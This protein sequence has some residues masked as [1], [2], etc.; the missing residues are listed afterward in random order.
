MINNQN[1]IS[2]PNCNSVFPIDESKY[3]I[4]SQQVRTKEFNKELENKLK[5]ELSKSLKISE[6]Q[7]R[8]DF[9]ESLNNKDKRILELEAKINLQSAQDKIKFKNE[10]DIKDKE[11]NKLENKLEQYDSLSQL[12][13]KEA[14]DEKDKVI[15]NLENKIELQNANHSIEIKKETEEKEE[16]INQLKIEKSKLLAEQEISELKIKEKHLIEVTLLKDEIERRKNFQSSF[17]K[18]IGEDL[19]DYCVNQFE[20][21]RQDGFRRSTFEKDNVLINGIKGDFIFRDFDEEGD[22]IISIMF[23]MKNESDKT[24]DE[25]KKKNKEFYPTL[26]KNRIQKNCEYAVLVS[27]L[28][29]DNEFFNRGIVEINGYE[30]LFV[31]RPQFFILIIS[32]LRNMSIKKSED[33]RELQI[34]KQNNINYAVLSDN[35]N[36]FR[37]GC[38]EKI[39]LASGDFSKM[40]T[41]IDQTISKLRKLREFLL[42]AIGNLKLADNKLHKFDIENMTESMKLLT[43]G[44]DNS[45][46]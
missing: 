29:K 15:N 16:E 9:K 24:K 2:C 44:D 46:E 26:N 45:K 37:E 23:D 32:L 33:K 38:L 43:T 22:E 28:E 14:K 5:L 1:Q 6:N 12:K 10:L 7:L 39:K 13:I 34:A 36:L 27:D 25:N 30:K 31:V 42:S 18:I 3:A 19:E 35:M 17:S 21:V 40:L 4:I 8:S 11:I 41:L 20:C